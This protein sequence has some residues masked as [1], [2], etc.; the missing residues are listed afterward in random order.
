[1]TDEVAPPGKV[2]AWLWPIAGALVCLGLGTAVGLTMEGGGGEWYQGLTKPPGNPPPWVFGPV[3]GVLYVLMGI[4]AG[5]LIHRRAMG[6]VTLF[7]IQFILN[8]AWTPVFFGAHAIGWALAVIFCVWGFLA[9]TIRSAEKVD[10]L[11]ALLL[12]PYLMWIMFATYLNA[13]IGWLNRA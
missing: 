1:M 5:R 6:A 3:W 4:A 2:S 10:H 13:A 8:L 9:L 11:S 7:V 12:M